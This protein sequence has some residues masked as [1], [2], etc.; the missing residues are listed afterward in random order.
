MVNIE[1]DIHV[2]VYMGMGICTFTHIPM[3]ENLL[4][5]K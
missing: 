1:M 3:Y 5:L 4:F 2:C